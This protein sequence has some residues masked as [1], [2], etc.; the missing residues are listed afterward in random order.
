MDCRRDVPQY[1]VILVIGGILF[2]TC[3][4]VEGLSGTRRLRERSG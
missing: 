2:R 1:G 3:R 4:Q